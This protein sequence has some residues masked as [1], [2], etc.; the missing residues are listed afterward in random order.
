M[1]LLF[2]FAT[3]YNA[4]KHTLLYGRNPPPICGPILS[5]ADDFMSS[6]TAM[7]ELFVPVYFPESQRQH[8][9]V[10]SMLRQPN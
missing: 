1:T 2:Y 5:C 10:Q 8:L 7:Y 4:N 6:L 3:L 9:T